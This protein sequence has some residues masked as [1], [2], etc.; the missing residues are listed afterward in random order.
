M[1]VP[2]RKTSKSV[3]R[4]R[5]GGKNL[6]APTLVKDPETGEYSVSHQVDAK[7]FYKGEQIIQIKEKK[8][9]EE[10]KK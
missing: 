1:A 10:E 8:E 3:K 9:K 4:V 7:G 5:R 6:I 2:F